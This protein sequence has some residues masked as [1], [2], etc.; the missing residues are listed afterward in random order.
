EPPPLPATDRPRLDHP[1]RVPLVRIVA[2]VVRVQGG[3][4]AHDLLVLPVRPRG[5]NTDGDRLVGL[6]RDDDALA[7]LRLA[8]TV[9]ASRGRRGRRRL[10]ARGAGLLASPGAP[11]APV[12]GIAL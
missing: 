2:L 5:V 8:G 1:D 7:G 6:R 9:L 11:A 10:R 12:R 4:R 3:G